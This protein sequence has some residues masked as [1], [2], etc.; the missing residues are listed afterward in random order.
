MPR[1]LTLLGCL[2]LIGPATGM[3]E[4]DLPIHLRVIAEY[5]EVPHELLTEVMVSEHADSGP[6][7]HARMRALVQEKK[8]GIM[9]TVILSARPGQRATVES[10]GEFIAPAEYNPP[11]SEALPPSDKNYGPRP[12]WPSSFETRNVGV[13]LEVEPNVGPNNKVIDIRFTPELVDRLRLETWV[14]YT[15]E[16]GDASVRRPTYESLRMSTGVTLLAN[17]WGFVGL[18]TPHAEDGGRDFTRKI[19]LFIRV[20]VIPI[21]NPDTLKP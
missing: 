11:G 5:I 21:E 17:T 12:E 1:L 2:S 14:E 6:K 13:T 8:A 7:L 10:I 19:M 18:L 15:D 16:H 9:E 20:D 3:D 4:R